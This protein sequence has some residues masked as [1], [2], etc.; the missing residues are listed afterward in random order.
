MAEKTK[1]HPS[2]TEKNHSITYANN[3][4]YFSALEK[5]LQSVYLWQNF[6]TTFA[7]AP[8][9][10]RFASSN[11]NVQNGISYMSATQ[12]NSLRFRRQVATVRP[13]VHIPE[14]G[15]LSHSKVRV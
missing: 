9:I 11:V 14:G 13:M 1:T 12:D 10:D 5:W 4:E 8:M 3:A 2:D 15:K 7:Y 6:V